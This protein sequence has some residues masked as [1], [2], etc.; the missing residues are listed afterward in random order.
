MINNY[1]KQCSEIFNYTYVNDM[2]NKDIDCK[3][4]NNGIILPIKG[5][6]GGVLDNIDN[7][8]KESSYNG[9]HIKY[10]GKYNY[11]NDEINYLN[12]SVV[13][14]GK[15]I[16]HWGHFLGDSISRLHIINDE[17]FDKNVK[18]V[19]ITDESQHIGKN[20]Y[21]FFELLGINKD[22]II[23]Q[24]NIVRYNKVYIP[25]VSVDDRFNC[26]KQYYDIFNKAVKSIDLSAYK[27]I[28]KV[29]FTRR[30]FNKAKISEVGEEEIENNFRKN[31]FVVLSPEKM[32][33]KEQIAIFNTSDV[34]ASLNGTISL[35]VI[36]NM[37][38]N[39]LVVLNKS[40]LLHK[41]LFRNS[42]KKD[43]EITYIDSYSEP[44][45]GYPKS[46]GY[47]PFF[48]DTTNELKRYFKDNNFVFCDTPKY[49]ELFKLV[50]YLIM[51]LKRIV[52]DIYKKR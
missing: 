37:A 31:G 22:D 8:V 42:Y 25:S 33:L 12:H 41:D 30:N 1:I 19:F 14:L 21:E 7:F 52:A 47:G 26:S 3:V 49:V 50:I 46:I 43:V 27:K 16:E 48:L 18:Y 35:N 4:V 9:I 40:R 34:I 15:F 51:I 17:K 5:N 20:H 11:R 32:S 24:K 10:G 38:K 13:Y 6:L 36:F 28:N 45:K 44:I 2:Y 29:Y 39:K 23:I